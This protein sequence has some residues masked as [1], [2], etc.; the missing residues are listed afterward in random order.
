M[1]GFLSSGVGGRR[2]VM[3]ADGEGRLEVELCAPPLEIE[4][5]AAGDSELDCGIPLESNGY[6][7]YRYGPC[8]KPPPRGV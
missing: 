6:V 3:M 8:V 1:S 7:L 2:L 5:E 4:A